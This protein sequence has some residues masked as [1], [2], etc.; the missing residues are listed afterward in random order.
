MEVGHPNDNIT[1]PT[2]RN[3]LVG[4]VPES[5][6]RG[7]VSLLTSCLVTTALCTWVVI[8]PR[9]DGRW[10]RQVL[11]KFALWSKTILAPELIAVEAAQ[12]YVQAQ[13]IVKRA[14]KTTNGEL[15][16][17]QAF[18]IGMFGI[19]YHTPLGT[20]I[21]WP[22]QFLWLLD[23][24]L[25]DW[26]NHAAWGLSSATISDK[27]SADATVKVFALLQI[28]WFV[29]Q[30]IMRTAHKLPLAPLE[31]MT[32]SYI[33]LFAM[34]YAYWW[35]KP[36]DIETPSEIELPYMCQSQRAHFDS[37]A[38]SDV[39]D[40]E[41]T[42]QQESLW[43][44]WTLTPRMFEQEAAEK[45]FE[46]E[47]DKYNEQ[48]QGFYDH[49]HACSDPQCEENGHQR[50]LPPLRRRET[51][52]AH[53]DPSLYHSRILWP[54]ACLAGI[55][56]PALHL[57]SWH[58]IFPTLVE[59]WLWRISAIVSMVAMLVFMQFEKVVFRWRD[60]LM[61]IKIL[62]PALYLITRVIMLVGAFA[63][64]R[65]ADPK[66]YDTYVMSSFWVHLV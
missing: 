24:G 34:A 66:I 57:I 13:T 30:S 20:R 12:E 16:L 60:P 44:I 11:H 40:R 64:F 41:G 62:S 2:D 42:K 61:L 18:Y 35:I 28:G 15:C 32:L 21:L 8:H 33:P 50:P 7:T 49:I 38:I 58:S 55:S 36:K 37:M 65:A 43:N 3:G 45:A 26:S 47:E 6:G 48:K 51:T 46:E 31:S 53:W 39:F 54:I 23:Q 27:G 52:L 14:S 5:P 63:A 9:I 22:N 10:K 1:I 56:F 17:L 25:L 29:V 19:R 59:T 4:W